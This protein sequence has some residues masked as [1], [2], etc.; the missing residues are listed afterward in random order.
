M[1]S[2]LGTYI[3]SGAH[4]SALMQVP[5]VRRGREDDEGTGASSYK[6]ILEEVG[7]FS[8]QKSK[9]REAYPCVSIPGGS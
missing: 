2:K 6:E 3:S 1:L 7:L 8:P 5:T 9:L 4:C